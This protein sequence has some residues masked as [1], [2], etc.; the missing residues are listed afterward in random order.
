MKELG[1]IVSD[2]CGRKTSTYGHYESLG[3]LQDDHSD[4]LKND[5]VSTT[6]DMRTIVGLAGEINS[7]SIDKGYVELGD[8]YSNASKRVESSS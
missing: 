5:F 8:E 3:S 6:M 4:V 2:R 7:C 1:R